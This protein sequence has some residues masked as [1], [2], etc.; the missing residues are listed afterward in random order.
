MSTSMTSMLTTL[1]R[2]MSMSK[3]WTGET[4]IPLHLT[5]WVSKVILSHT[6]TNTEI[7]LG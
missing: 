5:L 3:H 7:E 6:K 1:I 2:W 4:F